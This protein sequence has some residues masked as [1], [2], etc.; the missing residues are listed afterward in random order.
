[1][2][3]L[4]RVESAQQGPHRV[5]WAMRLVPFERLTLRTDSPPEA[6]QAKLLAL[7]SQSR[8][9]LKAPSEPFHGLVQGRHFKV[10]R[11]RR[12]ALGL[13]SRRSSMPVVVGDLVPFQGGTEVRVRIRPTASTTLFLLVWLGLLLSTAGAVLWKGA[14]EG[15]GS[16]VAGGPKSASPGG[17]LLFIGAMVAVGYGLASISFW[18]EVKR[19]RVALCEG[20]GCRAV[21]PQNRLVRG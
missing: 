19:A 10:I 17:M 13:R 16:P 14:K 7:V 11:T 9:T 5:C 21:E 3:P 6:V 1:M 4:G 12:N 20:L 2:R 18:M 15:L 8:F